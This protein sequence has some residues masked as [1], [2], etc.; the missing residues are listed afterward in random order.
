MGTKGKCLT[1]LLSN[2]LSRYIGLISYSLYLWHWALLSIYLNAMRIFPSTISCLILISLSTA[3]ASATYH[4]LEVPIKKLH[5]P[6]QIKVLAVA[7]VSLSVFFSFPSIHNWIMKI[8]HKPYSRI[9]S[10]LNKNSAFYKEIENVETLKRIRQKM[11]K[12][13]KAVIAAQSCKELGAPVEIHRFCRYYGGSRPSKEYIFVWGDSIAHVW[14]KTLSEISLELDTKIILVAH[15]ACPPILGL[16]QSQKDFASE[17]CDKGQVQIHVKEFL[18]SLDVSHI[19]LISRWNLYA[20]GYFKGG[21]RISH[22]FFIENDA[23]P[24]N[25]FYSKQSFSKKLTET[26]NALSSQSKIILFASNPILNSP[27]PE[28]LASKE[29]FYP[30]KSEFLNFESF[31]HKQLYRLAKGKGIRVLDLTNILCPTNYCEPIINGLPMYRDDVHLTYYA[32]SLFKADI[33]NLILENN[34]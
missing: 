10:L 32:T 14:R 28:G 7:M 34:A 11:L 12:P 9:I 19:L 22:Q 24:K 30:K 8:S 20:H 6:V 16:M 5:H 27:I 18:K 15:A 23:L 26:V 17:Y 13:Q 4:W 25:E 2:P 21:S 3:M 33:I 29:I 31:I 1:P